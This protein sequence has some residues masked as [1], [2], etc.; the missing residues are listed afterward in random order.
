MAAGRNYSGSHTEARPYDP[1]SRS[2]PNLEHPMTHNR[3][4]PIRVLIT[5]GPTHEPIDA[6]RYLANR[7]SGRL[8]VE[9][10]DAA[11]DRGLQTRLLIG[12]VP[13]R[14]RSPNI[15]THPFTTT[16]DLQALLAE[17]AEWADLLVMAAAVAD[18]RPLKDLNGPTDKI[19]RTDSG[20]T[21]NLEPTPDLLA[22]VAATRRPG[23]VLVGFALEP[24]E[25]LEA[26]AQDKLRRKGID[27]I[28]AN[29]LETMD[30]Q[31]ITATLLARDPAFA[32]EHTPGKVHKDHFAAWLLD[33]LEPIARDA[34]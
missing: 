2:V 31:Q 9:L 11:A 20:L 19:R 18:Y 6:V 32:P 34:P 7:S 21:L 5:A 3:T 1:L 13:L 4:R 15:E 22:G 29:P 16:A 8:G 12:P 33:L 30:S 17:H 26:S 14:P 24:A 25:R 28:V 27:F 23:Q 10:A